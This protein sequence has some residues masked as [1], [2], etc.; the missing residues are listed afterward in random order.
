M[1][2]FIV[3]G[4]KSFLGS[5]VDMTILELGKVWLAFSIT[6]LNDVVWIRMWLGL[7]SW[8][9]ES[10]SKAVWMV[11]YQTLATLCL[12]KLFLFNKLSI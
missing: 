3:R 10:S 2:L 9:S 1:S 6:A 7:P 11:G 4:W 8:D 5:K 12:G